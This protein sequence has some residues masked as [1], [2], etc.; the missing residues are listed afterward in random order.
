MKKKQDFLDKTLAFLAEYFKDAREW[1]IGKFPFL[2]LILLLLFVFVWI[3]HIKSP[4]YNSIFFGLNL[5]IHELGHILFQ[6]FGQFIMTLGGSLFQC[7]VPFIGLVMFLKQR[8]YFAVAVAFGWEATNLYY[9][10]T[11]VNDA[12]A[13]ALPLVSPFGVEAYHDWNWILTEL[14]M[15]EYDLFLASVL[16]VLASACMVFCLVYG[17]WLVYIML[18]TFREKWDSLDDYSEY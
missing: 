10:A 17:G 12:T 14:G 1:A 2:R 7:I 16:R 15:L 4:L 6:P 9:V 8:D 18:K 11:Y 13:M 3:R 5:G